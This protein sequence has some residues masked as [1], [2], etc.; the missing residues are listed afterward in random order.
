MYNDSVYSPT[1][2]CP[3]HNATTYLNQL[4]GGLRAESQ[5]G[6]IVSMV[7]LASLMQLGGIPAPVH[8]SI[9]SLLMWWV[10]MLMQFGEFAMRTELGAPPTPSANGSP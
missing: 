5:A 9:V 4:Q 2:C 1:T 8:G 7:M 10:W 3:A 6:S